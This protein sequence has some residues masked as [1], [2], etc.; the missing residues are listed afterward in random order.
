MDEFVY[1]D[2]EDT[3]FPVCKNYH[4]VL[5]KDFG[6]N[7]MTPPPE[8]KRITHADVVREMFFNLQRE[9]ELEHSK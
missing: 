9:Y 8:D 3:Q 2:F 7:Y 5:I 6:L 1:V 4:E